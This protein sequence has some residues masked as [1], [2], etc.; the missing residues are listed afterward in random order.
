MPSQLQKV[1]NSRR[2]LN[3]P[4]ENQVQ[5]ASGEIFTITIHIRGRPR[6]RT[7][8]IPAMVIALA[9]G[10]TLVARLLG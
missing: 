2:R 1:H 3:R 9:W 5:C 10:M 7:A 6:G 8:A 4:D